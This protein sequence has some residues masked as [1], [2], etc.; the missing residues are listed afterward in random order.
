MKTPEKKCDYNRRGKD[1]TSNIKIILYSVQTE[2]HI[3]NMHGK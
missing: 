3:F 2:N 1:I